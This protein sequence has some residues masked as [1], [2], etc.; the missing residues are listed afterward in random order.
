MWTVKAQHCFAAVLQHCCKKSCMLGSTT[1][2]CS[3]NEPT[4]LPK[5][6]AEIKLEPH[7]LTLKNRHGM[8]NF[9]HHADD[10]KAWHSQF[11]TCKRI[12]PKCNVA[13]LLKFLGV[14]RLPPG[15]SLGKAKRST[16]KWGLSCMF[17]LPVLP[18]L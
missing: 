13:P 3:A 2:S 11:S 16:C 8:P 14:P 7:L 18:K 10:F 12:G 4:L 15:G 17:L 9:W 1:S 5:R 6:A